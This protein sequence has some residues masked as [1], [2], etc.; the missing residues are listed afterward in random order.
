MYDEKIPSFMRETISSSRKIRRHHFR[1]DAE[2]LLSKEMRSFLVGSRYSSMTTIDTEAPR[3]SSIPRT[4]N[5][6]RSPHSKGAPFLESITSSLLQPI[7]KPPSFNAPFGRKLAPLYSEAVKRYKEQ[8]GIM[9][10][11]PRILISHLYCSDIKRRPVSASPSSTAQRSSHSIC[12]EHS[13][14]ENEVFSSI[15]ESKKDKT[16][17][18]CTKVRNFN[19]LGYRLSDYT[20]NFSTSQRTHSA[21]L[22]SQ[23]QYQK[24]SSKLNNSINCPTVDNHLW[25][26]DIQTASRERRSFSAD[27]A[28]ES[29]MI[30]LFSKSLRESIRDS[31]EL[32]PEMKE[33]MGLHFD[34][35]MNVA[36]KGDETAVKHSKLIKEEIEKDGL[37]EQSIQN[38]DENDETKQ[39]DLASLAES[40][41]SFSSFANPA[42]LAFAQKDINSVEEAHSSSVCEKRNQRELKCEIRETEIENGA[43]NERTEAAASISSMQKNATIV[44]SETPRIIE[45]SPLS[46]EGERSRMDNEYLGSDTYRSSRPDEKEDAVSGDDEGL[47]NVSHNSECDRSC[48]S[49]HSSSSLQ[50][51]SPHVKARQ[52]P[53]VAVPRLQLSAL[54]FFAPSPRRPVTPHPSTCSTHSS[55]ESSPS[56]ELAEYEAEE[57]NRKISTK[58]SRTVRPSSSPSMLAT[59]H[60]SAPARDSQLRHTLSH[61]LQNDGSGSL[62]ENL[63]TKTIGKG[64][65]STFVSNA[66][67]EE[68]E[69][70]E[71]ELCDDYSNQMERNEEEDESKEMS[72]S[73][74]QMKSNDLEAIKQFW[75]EADEKAKRMKKEAAEKIS[76]LRDSSKSCD[77]ETRSFDSSETNDEDDEH[78]DENNDESL[79]LK[80]SFNENANSFRDISDEVSAIIGKA[81]PEDSKDDLPPLLPVNEW[82]DGKQSGPSAKGEG[83]G[84]DKGMGADSPVIHSSRSAHS[85]NDDDDDDDGDDYDPEDR[86][87]YEEHLDFDVRSSLGE[88]VE[89]AERRMMQKIASE[90]EEEE[91]KEEAENP[92]KSEMDNENEKKTDEKFDSD[93]M[94][95]RK[96]GS[97]ETKINSIQKSSQKSLFSKP[98]NV[99]SFQ[100]NS[101]FLKGSQVSDKINKADKCNPTGFEPA[102]SQSTLSSSLGEWKSQSEPSSSFALSKFDSTGKCTPSGSA[103]A[104]AKKSE[105]ASEI[106]SYDTSFSSFP[107]GT[108]SPAGQ[109]PK[110]RSYNSLPRSD[111]SAPETAQISERQSYR[112]FQA[113]LSSTTL[114]SCSS[115]A[116]I[117]LSKAFP[118]SSTFSHTPNSLYRF[119]SATDRSYASSCF[120]PAG[121]D[122]ESSS[123]CST[124]ASDD[125]EDDWSQSA[126]G[127]S[128]SSCSCS[129]YS[130]SISSADDAKN[131][132]QTGK[133]R[134]DAEVESNATAEDFD[135]SCCRHRKHQLH[136]HYHPHRAAT[137]DCA[138]CQKRRIQEAFQ[139]AITKCCDG[140]LSSRR[141]TDSALCTY[142]S[143]ATMDRSRS[144]SSSSLLMTPASNFF[145]RTAS[146]PYFSPPPSITSFADTADSS[147]MAG[148]F[149]SATSPSKESIG[150]TYFSSNASE[151]SFYT[152]NNSSNVVSGATSLSL[153]S[154]GGESKSNSNTQSSEDVTARYTSR[155][156]CHIHHKPSKFFSDESRANLYQEQKHG[157]TDRKRR[158]SSFDNEGKRA[159]KH[160]R[161]DG[162]GRSRQ[163]SVLSLAGY[164]ASLGQLAYVSDLNGKDIQ[165][166]FNDKGEK[167]PKANENDLKVKNGKTAEAIL[168]RRKQQ[169]QPK[170]PKLSA[171]AILSSLLE[172]KGEASALTLRQNQ[173]SRTGNAM[174][175]PGSK[176][177]AKMS[178]IKEKEGEEGEEGVNEE[179]SAEISVF[180]PMLFQPVNIAQIPMEPSMSSIP[181]SSKGTRWNVKPSQSKLT[182][183]KKIKGN[184]EQQLH[185]QQSNLLSPNVLPH[186]CS[187]GAFPPEPTFKAL[188][189]QRNI[190]ISSKAISERSTS[191]TPQKQLLKD[192]NGRFS[193][194]DTKR[195]KTAL[196]SQR[197]RIKPFGANEPKSQFGLHR[198]LYPSTLLSQT[199]QPT[200]TQPRIV[201]TSSIPSASASSSPVITSTSTQAI[202]GL[203]PHLS[204]ILSAINTPTNNKKLQKSRDSNSDPFET[205]LSI[206]SKSLKS[207]VLTALSSTAPPSSSVSLFSIP[208]KASNDAANSLKEQDADDIFLNLRS[209][210]FAPSAQPNISSS[211]NHSH[212]LSVPSN[213]PPSL[214]PPPSHLLVSPSRALDVLGASAYKLKHSHS[215]SRQ[216]H[217]KDKQAP[218]DSDENGF[219]FR[220]HPLTP[221]PLTPTTPIRSRFNSATAQII[222][223]ETAAPL[224]T[225]VSSTEAPISPT[226]DKS[227]K[228]DTISEE[229]AKES[230]SSDEINKDMSDMLCTTL[231]SHTLEAINS[232]LTESCVT[233]SVDDSLTELSITC[234]SNNL[235]AMQISAPKLKTVSS[236]QLQQKQNS[237]TNLGK[238]EEKGDGMNSSQ[239]QDRLEDT[240]LTAK[241]TSKS[242]LENI[243]AK[244]KRHRFIS[245]H[246]VHPPSLDFTNPENVTS[247]QHLPMESSRTI[248]EYFMDSPSITSSSSNSSLLQKP[249]M[250]RDFSSGISLDRTTTSSTLLSTYSTFG[251]QMDLDSMDFSTERS[252]CST[253]YSSSFDDDKEFLM[254]PSHSSPKQSKSKL[255]DQSSSAKIQ[256]F[257]KNEASPEPQQMQNTGI[258]SLSPQNPFISTPAERIQRVPL[259]PVLVQQGM[260]KTETE[261]RKERREKLREEAEKRKFQRNTS[262]DHGKHESNR[263]AKEGNQMQY[264]YSE[265][266]KS[267]SREI[268]TNTSKMASQEIS[269]VANY[270]QSILSANEQLEMDQPTLEDFSNVE[271]EAIDEK[272]CDNTAI[273]MDEKE[274]QRDFAVSPMNSFQQK[275]TSL[276]SLQEQEFTQEKKEEIVFSHNNSVDGVGSTENSDIFQSHVN[277]YRDQNE[278]DEDRVELESV[279]EDGRSI[280]KAKMKNRFVDCTGYSDEHIYRD[281]E[282]KDDFIDSISKTSESGKNNVNE[283]IDEEKSKFC[284]IEYHAEQ[285]E[286]PFNDE[287]ASGNPGN[288]STSTSAQFKDE[289]NPFSSPKIDISSFLESSL[290]HSSATVNSPKTYNT[291]PTSPSSIHS[292]S[293][294][295]DTEP[296]QPANDWSDNRSNLSP[297]SFN[298][299]T[300]IQ[301]SRSSTSVP[302]HKPKPASLISP[303]GNSLKKSSFAFDTS[304]HSF[305]SNITFPSNNFL[306]SPKSPLSPL[307]PLPS[308]SIIRGTSPM[309][310]IRTT[311]P[312]IISS[313]KEGSNSLTSSSSFSEVSS[314]NTVFSDSSQKQ[315]SAKD[316]FFS[317]S[318]FLLPPKQDS[319]STQSPSSKA[320]TSSP[321]GNE[322]LDFD[323]PNNENPHQTKRA[324][325]ANSI[326]SWNIPPSTPFNSE[327]LAAPFFGSEELFSSMPPLPPPSSPASSSPPSRFHTP[328][329]SQNEISL[330]PSSDLLADSLHSKME[331]TGSDFLIAEN[332]VPEK[333]SV[334]I[335]QKES[336]LQFSNNNV[337]QASDDSRKI[338]GDG[339]VSCS[340]S[341]VGNREFSKQRKKDMPKPKWVATKRIG[342][343]NPH[344]NI[345]T[346]SPTKPKS[347]A[348]SQKMPFVGSCSPQRFYRTKQQTSISSSPTPLVSKN[349]SDITSTPI[350]LSNTHHS[351]ISASIKS[352]S[353]QSKTYTPTPESISSLHNTTFHSLPQQNFSFTGKNSDAHSFK[354]HMPSD[355]REKQSI[356]DK[357]SETNTLS[358]IQKV[359]NHSPSKR[360]SHV[361]LRDI[362]PLQII[363]DSIVHASSFSKRK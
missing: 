315:N 274:I 261:L 76:K 57:K 269:C 109:F 300:P 90:E 31:I 276:P 295:I 40:T 353:S 275:N 204:P 258:S 325:S 139:E 272:I 225:E 86:R 207:P 249:H 281:Y 203:S 244:E 125:D 29:Q 187:F 114:S 46:V 311:Q 15:H 223:Q 71:E 92:T 27:G 251:S 308:L 50:Q 26:A 257:S 117:P 74:L 241:D 72:N 53:P 126:S 303:T 178:S 329:L 99:S 42:D 7:P 213:P 148:G 264:P 70:E 328:P 235:S 221:P 8:G 190:P 47:S 147:S 226:I 309:Q 136:R 294:D 134:D 68:E 140:T 108:S 44:R 62:N 247:Q 145:G 141:Q 270:S 95:I 168:L 113:P 188:P 115:S 123:A 45:R 351:L 312:K 341:K 20:D 119:S 58:E 324:V 100:I 24:K 112:S 14:N 211:Q 232:K 164:D 327:V 185:Q 284:Q 163:N 208:G 150:G 101:S 236:S 39:E 84:K 131:N 154:T 181:F 192:D 132:R 359:V 202:N 69:E 48:C 193:L 320:L 344:V 331:Q 179:E 180:D 195:S 256:L 323:E 12:S 199:S 143:G 201:A 337:E 339:S 83:K 124:S 78:F 118:S 358:L 165:N 146:H 103:S 306:S 142:R 93:E 94:I 335:P 262:P 273:D 348:I 151:A 218:S 61:A 246:R 259:L 189:K 293:S 322:T 33:E 212:L 153:Q 205:S 197:R 302:F 98:S 198:L 75:I 242:S 304:A 137:C 64:S 268:A 252:L 342:Q 310:D 239:K 120:S 162:K 174:F 286:H 288:F 91:E 25:S 243:G 224:T 237:Q 65:E 301:N 352:A 361:Q 129:F 17:D 362:Q 350:N 317:V 155:H 279:G 194:F 52:M 357:R 51:Q 319:H 10:I 28:V 36:F 330:A 298:Y 172:G 127:S 77:F 240:K 55:K 43:E 130:H 81:V 349:S 173:L 214:I 102:T 229:T 186:P 210:S 346:S 88:E 158:N 104:L 170:S 233:V 316:E 196:P 159:H 216:H 307:P 87:Q 265:R 282:E 245:Y 305:S 169:K 238:D 318:P 6:S 38:S 66:K 354:V 177:I 41:V 13:S 334:L 250:T 59:P 299:S 230:K 3:E 356:I 85:K 110:L 1:P 116:S 122:T 35:L 183:H 222:D 82:E 343:L 63:S 283:K 287:L 5:F 16:H 23:E 60:N 67:E 18:D 54:P 332:S 4:Q 267:P 157:Q 254:T 21:S 49:E 121:S 219:A 191:N 231:D 167:D 34:P 347:S 260:I 184:D 160:K 314:F 182:R 333:S 135:D 363:G 217:L 19:L 340:K 171:N 128:W 111:H 220:T 345:Q 176:R 166:A 30:G 255:A 133:E 156:R 209:L 37:D 107:N 290:P 89:E 336:D 80:D 228:K 96:S 22:N 149:S 326:S 152:S 296:I 313:L 175:Q 105:T 144:A 11:L 278:S 97:K 215:H 79:Q 253:T 73:K 285:K 360:H 32:H 161:K 248:S 206:Q 291:H 289:E 280:G 234:G 271:L 2:A 297:S 263:F 321:S 138:R 266:Q 106:S 277:I 200:P 338:G 9:K 292:T 227:I 355:V 56:Q